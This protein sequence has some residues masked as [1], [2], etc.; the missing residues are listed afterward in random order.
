MSMTFGGIR[1]DS[2]VTNLNQKATEQSR[3][4]TSSKTPRR[5]VVKDTL[6]MKVQS[7]GDTLAISGLKEL[8]AANSQSFRDQV[9]AS[10]TDGQKNIEIDL[11]Q[12]MFI[13]SCG[14]GAL[15]ALHKAACARQG[16][17]RLLHPTPPVLQILE[18][19]R[20]HRIFEVVNNS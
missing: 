3:L 7:R 10:L 18:L 20:M 15:I 17:V 14:L 6:I 9:R 8:A 13:D 2:L 12:T 19:T 1:C 11:S 4:A 5:R 16:Q